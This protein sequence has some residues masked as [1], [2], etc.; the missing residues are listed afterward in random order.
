MRDNIDDHCCYQ[1]DHLLLVV[2]SEA[3]DAVEAMNNCYYSSHNLT[4]SWK[5][6]KATLLPNMYFLR[7]EV[8]M[9]EC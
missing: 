7:M 3:D 1:D 4:T 9:D 8:E 6:V 5:I 2:S